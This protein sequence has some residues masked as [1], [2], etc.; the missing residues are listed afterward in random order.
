MTKQL[1]CFKNEKLER[2][3]F[4]LRFPNPVGVAA[5]FD[6]KAKLYNALSNFGF[7]HVEIGTV[8]PLGQKGNPKPRLFRL[9]ND[10]ALINRMGFNNQGV[11]SFVRNIR[12]NNPRVIIGG[13]IGKNTLTPNEEA[14]NDYCHCFGALYDYVDY[15]VVNISCPNIQNLGKLQDKDHMLELFTAIQEVNNSKPKKRPVLIK[16]SPDLNNAQLD[17]VIDIVEE[18]GLDGIIA[19]NT[20][21]QRT[22]LSYSK[23]RIQKTGNGGLSGKPLRERSTKCIEYIHKRSKGKIPI[24]GVGGI[25]SADDALEKLQAGA[26]LVQVYTGFI[27]QGPSIAKKINQA[28]LNNI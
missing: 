13:N 14:I 15:F 21:T 6:K 4:G 26:S 20:T 16:I 10:K 27:Y 11:E 22:H 28:L 18:T 2:Q 19:T 17:D 9:P 5:G 12:K 8:T 24:I 25:F 3:L 7:G 23:E 1:F